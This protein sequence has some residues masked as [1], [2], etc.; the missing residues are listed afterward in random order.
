[1]SCVSFV[2]NCLNNCE[3][4]VWHNDHDDGKKWGTR[5]VEIVGECEECGKSINT[6]H[7]VLLLVV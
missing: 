3:T 1:M 6:H 5:A 4:N 7:I 2:A